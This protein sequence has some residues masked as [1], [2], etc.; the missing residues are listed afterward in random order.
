MIAMG[1][2]FLLFVGSVVGVGIWMTKRSKEKVL[3][4]SPWVGL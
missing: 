1:V 2:Y 4:R 3:R